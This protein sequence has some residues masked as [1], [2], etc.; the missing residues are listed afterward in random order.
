MSLTKAERLYYGPRELFH[1]KLYSNAQGLGVSPL[2]ACWMK[3]NTLL[4][5]DQFMLQ[6]YSLQRSPSALLILRGRREDVQ[7]SWT[8]MMQKSRE[9]PN[10]IWP[11]VIEGAEG[12]KSRIIEYQQFDLKPIEWQWSEM[13]KEFRDVVGAV[14]G[15]QPIFSSGASSSQGG[16]ANEGLQLAVTTLAVKQAQQKWNEF[17]Q[18]LSRQLG[19]EDYWFKLNPNEQ[20]DEIRD[21]EVEQKRVAIAQAMKEM[22]GWEIELHRDAKGR[23]EFTYVEAPVQEPGEGLLPEGVPTPEDEQIPSEKD[24][25]PLADAQSPEELRRSEQETEER[26]KAGPQVPRE[27]PGTFMAELDTEKANYKSGPAVGGKNRR[28]PRGDETA[29]T[30]QVG[31]TQN[32]AIYEGSHVGGMG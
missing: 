28:I 10:M 12:D 2:K 1:I 3:V 19:G 5:M 24:M 6:A 15:V 13:R 25:P 27:Q 31:G 30:T 21:L 20:E 14:Y 22:G 32:M 18:F 16:L 11:L 17:L 8:W 23:V 4:R 29:D 9:N 7:R 26:G